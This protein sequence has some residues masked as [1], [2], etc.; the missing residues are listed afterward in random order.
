MHG[1]AIELYAYRGMSEVLISLISQHSETSIDTGRKK[2]GKILS[3]DRQEKSEREGRNPA[4]GRIP[5]AYI[6]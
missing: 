3:G 6:C 5:E 4:E 1:I 2:R